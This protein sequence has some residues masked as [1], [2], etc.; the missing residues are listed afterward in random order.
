MGSADVPLEIRHRPASPGVTKDQAPAPSAIGTKW[1]VGFETPLPPPVAVKIE[2]L[3]IANC[4]F[5][6]EG[7]EALM[8]TPLIVEPF[9]KLGEL[10]A[11]PLFT[12]KS[13]GQL[14]KLGS[15]LVPFDVRQKPLVLGEI[16]ANA[17]A[18]SATGT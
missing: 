13:P 4:T 7:F 6:A 16:N 3:V 18:P 11:E 14:W 5:D 1:A 9:W 12:V 8:V 10:N 17:L 15:A 2:P